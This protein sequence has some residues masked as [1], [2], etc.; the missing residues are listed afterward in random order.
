MEPAGHVMDECRFESMA[1]AHFCG[2][3]ADRDRNVAFRRIEQGHLDSTHQTAISMFPEQ[4]FDRG[5]ASGR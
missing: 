4:V 5:D 1:T 3:M 2:L